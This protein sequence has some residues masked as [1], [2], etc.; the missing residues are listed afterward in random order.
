MVTPT[1]EGDHSPALQTKVMVLDSVSWQKQG[2][3]VVIGLYAEHTTTDDGTSHEVWQGWGS[4]RCMYES[5]TDEL[6]IS[7]G[8]GI[9]AIVKVGGFWPMQGLC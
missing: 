8:S 6:E 7:I 3:A 2:G 9:P 4:V 1:G 5:G